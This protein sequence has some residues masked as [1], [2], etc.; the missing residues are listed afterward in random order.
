MLLPYGWHE[1]LLVVDLEKGSC[2]YIESRREP[3]KKYIGG[4]GIGAFY[5][6][7]YTQDPNVDPLGNR[8][9]IILST[10]P[11]TATP[12]PT[13]GR[14]SASF[15]SPL[16]MTLADTNL[17]GVFGFLMKTTG[18]DTLIIKGKAPEPI[19]IYLNGKQT[20]ILPASHLWGKDNREVTSI[21][22]KQ[23]GKK[24]SVL[25][26][27]RAGEKLVKFA[28]VINDSKRAFGRGGLGAVFGAK[29][30]KAIVTVGGN[31]RPQIHSPADFQDFRYEV[32][33]HITTH[34]VT[35]K[36]L[37]PLGTSGVLRVINEFH[38]LG[39]RNFTSSHFAS[40]DKLSGESLRKFYLVRNY[41]CWGCP[42]ACGRISKVGSE[43]GGGPEFETLYA[44]GSNLG[45][46]DLKA[47][48]LVNFIADDLGMDTISLGGV[49]AFAMEA[50]ELGIYDFGIKFGETSKLIP[51]VKKIGLRED[52]A[53]DM[54]AEGVRRA[55]EK[56]KGTE[57][58]MHVK[59]MELPAYDPRGTQGMGLV[60]ATS[61]RGACHLRGGFSVSSEIFG[62][63]R[64]I[65][66]FQSVGK[67]THVARY[68]DS[69]AVIDSLII[70]KFT[71]FAT[72][73]H[74]WVRVYNAVTGEGL[75][76]ADLQMI[77]QRIFNL[78]R[79]IN[80]KLGF[81]K[82]YDTLPKR[83]LQEAIRIGGCDEHVVDMDTMLSEY[84][85]Y[86]GWDKNGVPTK[87]KILEL[88]LK[89]DIPWL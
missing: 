14:I 17:G 76:V 46:S 75:T 51:L 42:I 19:Y 85:E 79:I 64:R 35:S 73:L 82:E 40:A 60:Y 33:K 25:S 24:A 38:V 34:P 84:Y 28:C 55:S 1:K 66:R 3:L 31:N 8:N 63:P 72:S 65:N 36:V 59:G 87:E 45:I 81:T 62:V 5:F 11:L 56:V 89:E 54:L 39:T 74:H 21:L 61:N 83:F 47:V 6:L 70:C 88:G 37:K 32:L 58:A 80:L 71:T 12:S 86:R 57:I 15:R 4:R 22:K 41:G 29:N 67:G 48:T 44:L 26:I 10:G 9:P 68:Q 7:K 23:H 77:G 43:E 2:E 78:E 27:G 69:G 20:K 18:I 30:L 53:G 50:T 52:D 16:T 49:V 13:A